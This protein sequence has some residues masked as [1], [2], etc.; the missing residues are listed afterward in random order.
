MGAEAIL[1]EMADALERLGAKGDLV[2]GVSQGEDDLVTWDLG[3]DEARALAT[4][5]RLT[6]GDD[7][8]GSA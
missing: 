8:G 2:L 4:L 3:A 7:E 6:V 1:A 5:L